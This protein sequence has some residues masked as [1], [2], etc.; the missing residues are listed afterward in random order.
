MKVCN[1]GLKCRLIFYLLYSNKY[2]L[3]RL[4]PGSLNRRVVHAACVKIA[5][6]LLVA[7][8]AGVCILCGCFEDLVQLFLILVSKIV[9]AAPARIRGGD[10]IL[11][12]PATVS[13]LK[14]ISARRDAGIHVRNIEA[15][16][17]FGWFGFHKA[18]V[19]RTE[20]ER[21]SD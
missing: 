11:R 12:H 7:A 3:K 16:N 14:E 8:L 18:P 15:M 1:L 2:R 21:C 17:I 4:Q 13:V 5:N 19:D 6:L 10:L 9:E 20:K